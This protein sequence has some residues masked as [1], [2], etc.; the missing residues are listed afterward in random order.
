A[1]SSPCRSTVLSTRAP[2]LPSMLAAQRALSVA[3][4]LDEALRPLNG[5]PRPA[6]RLVAVEPARHG[7]AVAQA[8]TKG[9]QPLH[10]GELR[11][12]TEAVVL[13]ELEGSVEVMRVR[14]LDPP[15]CQRGLQ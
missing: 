12:Y 4:R 3:A 14:K 6:Q 15:I 1:S 13:A 7:C 9:R 5:R 10:A 8:N 2:H 11:R